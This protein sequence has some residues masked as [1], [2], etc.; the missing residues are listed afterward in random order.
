MEHLSTGE[1]LYLFY[2]FAYAEQDSNSVTKGTVKKH[3]PKNYR[4]QANEICNKLLTQKLLESPKRSRLTVSLHGRETLVENL[5]VTDYQFESQK[6]SKVVNALMYCLQLASSLKSKQKEDRILFEDFVDKFRELYFE[7]CKRQS[8][9]GTYVIREGEILN[10]FFE[11]HDISDRL[12]K[13]Y[14][15]RLQSEGF[16]SVLEGRKDKIIQWVE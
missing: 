12:L 7:E 13:S 2:T 5:Q 4:H 8:K 3:L 11:R 15:K 9:E 16:I 1:L 6:G 14:Y 10:L